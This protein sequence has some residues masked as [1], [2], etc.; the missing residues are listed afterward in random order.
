MTDADI[1]DALDGAILQIVSLGRERDALRCEV[2]LLRETLA[3]VGGER[4][5]LQLRVQQLD[6]DE[7][8]LDWL[9]ETATLDQVRTLADELIS[10]DDV[11]AAID[12][13]RGAK[14]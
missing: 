6:A 14:P 10:N 3:V 1:L 9:G 5:S 4:D 13:L 7:D 11:R 12:K 8:R 2:A